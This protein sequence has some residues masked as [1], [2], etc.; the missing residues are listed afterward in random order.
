[1]HPLEKRLAAL[2]SANP[3]ANELTIIRRI[4]SP[5]HLDAEIHRLRGDDGE[6]WTRKHGETEQEL[7]DRASL[8]A[9]RSPWGVA[10]LIGD[11]GVVAQ[12]D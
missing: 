5:G 7:I 11:D 10:R 6:L 9:K 2:E 8:E 4:V 12:T 1:M 3:P